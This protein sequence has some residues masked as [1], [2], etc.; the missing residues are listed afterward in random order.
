[1]VL[2]KE[3]RELIL[4]RMPTYE[5]SRVAKDQGMVRLRDDGLLKAAR[6]VTTVEEV[7]RTVV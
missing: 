6:G 5:I 3:I 7:L 2:T 1:M 4:R